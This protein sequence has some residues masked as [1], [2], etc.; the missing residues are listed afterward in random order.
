MCSD[1]SN[2][3][4]TDYSSSICRT[5]NSHNIVLIVYSFRLDIKSCPQIC[6]KISHILST[7][8]I[9]TIFVIVVFIFWTLCFFNDISLVCKRTSCKEGVLSTVHVNM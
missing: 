8:T 4:F 9:F 3:Y 2:I 6:D 7:G 1:Y 5:C